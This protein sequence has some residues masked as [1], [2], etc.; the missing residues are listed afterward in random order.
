MLQISVHLEYT[1]VCQIWSSS[2]EG[3]GTGLTGASTNFKIT[4]K[5]QF[6]TPEGKTLN[7]IR[8][9]FACKHGL[10]LCY[11]LLNL[12]WIRVS[13][14]PRKNGSDPVPDITTT[15]SAD[16]GPDSIYRMPAYFSITPLMRSPSN[17]V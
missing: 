12:V 7:R 6:F 5:L 9:N 13:N 4:P 11:R 10:C 1:A 16:P 3:M 2:A 14:G 15:V 8:L 17:A